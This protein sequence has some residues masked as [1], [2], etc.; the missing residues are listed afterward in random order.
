MNRTFR[1]ALFLLTISFMGCEERKVTVIPSV[2]RWRNGYGLD[3]DE[4]Q[5]MERNGVQ[6]VYFKLLDIGWNPANGA[7]PVSAVDVPYEWRDYSRERGPWTDKVE[8]VPCIYITNTTFEKLDATG[9]EELVHNLLRKLRMECP[10]K[11]HG[12]MLDCDWTPST[13][14]R[15]FQLTK[16]M[17]DSLTVPVITT[18]RLHQ[19]ADPG[20]TGVPPAD[21]G[22]L[23]VYNVGRLQDRSDVNSIFDKVT[24]APY[25]ANT[26]PYPLPLDLA[27]P[28]FSWGAQFR[29]GR[30][31]GILHEEQVDEALRRGLLHD[32]KDGLMQVIVEDNENLPELHLGDEIRMERIAPEH[33][34][35]AAQLARHAVNSDTVA[36][37]FF[38]VG[39]RSYQELDSVFV[40]GTYGSFGEARGSSLQGEHL[41]APHEEVI[42]M[43][44]IIA[45]DTVAMPAKP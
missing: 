23:M 10:V 40:A 36:I 11:L 25:F 35:E 34:T 33:I 5:A 43:P 8:F 14:D 2:F 12:V 45:V 32:P 7:H 9:T 37:A 44:E 22:M 30:F 27:L 29:K 18:I 39:A 26:K 24:A 3:R 31:Q 42:D 17:N 13:K 19:Y 6:R 28:A 38:Q 41:S 4:H 1:W 20:K 21:R 15:F 16:S